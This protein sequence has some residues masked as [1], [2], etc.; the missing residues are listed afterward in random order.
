MEKNISFS[1]SKQFQ[2]SHVSLQFIDRYQF[3]STSLEKLVAN[4]RLDDVKIWKENMINTDS[5]LRKGLYPYEYISSMQKFHE[6]TL[7][8]REAFFSTSAKKTMHMP[9]LFGIFS[10]FKTWGTIM[11]CTWR[12]MSSSWPTCSKIFQ[13]VCAVLSTRLWT[14]R[15]SYNTCLASIT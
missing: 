6:T 12:S 7:P 5:L 14:F 8:P 13:A 15:H 1:I 2:K 11:N 9:V 4:S 3:L 10:I